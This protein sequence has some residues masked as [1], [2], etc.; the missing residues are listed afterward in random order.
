VL[1]GTFNNAAARKDLTQEI[2]TTAAANNE[3][4]EANLN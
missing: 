3:A 1:Q 4:W 2:H